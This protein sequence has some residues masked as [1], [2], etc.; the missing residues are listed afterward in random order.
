M[1]FDLNLWT[2]IQSLSLK[3]TSECKNNGI[4]SSSKKPQKLQGDPFVKHKQFVKQS[5]ER[6]EKGISWKRCDLMIIWSRKVTQFGDASRP[7]KLMTKRMRN[8]MGG[9]REQVILS[10][11]VKGY[12]ARLHRRLKR[13]FLDTQRNLHGISCNHKSHWRLMYGK[14]D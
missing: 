4:H 3:P 11:A 6:E 12:T 5:Q 7:Q 2:H 14:Q 1:I 8:Y 13:L 10:R 9:R